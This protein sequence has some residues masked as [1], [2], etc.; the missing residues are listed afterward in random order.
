[1]SLEHNLRCLDENRE[2]CDCHV[3]CQVNNTV[4]TQK[5]MNTPSAISGSIWTYWSDENTFLHKENK[6]NDFIQQ[7][8]SSAIP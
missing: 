7:F 2:A 3:D 4:K 1:M 8:V 6:N 5:S